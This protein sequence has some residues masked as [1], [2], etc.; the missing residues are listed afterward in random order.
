VRYDKDRPPLPLGSVFVKCLLNLE[1]V[2]GSE[3]N[4]F[5][6]FLGRLGPMR[7]SLSYEENMNDL[8]KDAITTWRQGTGG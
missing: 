1:P 8:C 3:R 6:W 7:R 4:L 2:P 5:A